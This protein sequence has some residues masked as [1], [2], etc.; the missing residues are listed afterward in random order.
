[1]TII[2]GDAIDSIFR[3]GFRVTIHGLRIAIN[4]KI[5]VASSNKNLRATICIL[6]FAIGKVFTVVV[7]N[8][9]TTREEVTRVANWK[10]MTI[11]WTRFEGILATKVKRIIVFCKD[12][13]EVSNHLLWTIECYVEPWNYAWIAI[14]ILRIGFL[15]VVGTQ[16]KILRMTSIASCGSIFKEIIVATSLSIVKVASHVQWDVYI[17]ALTIIDCYR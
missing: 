12:E 13:L 6:W 11:L 8:I 4:E 9:W 5:V 3:E 10:V 16:S 17:D 7:V 1:M 2:Y 15:L 14:G